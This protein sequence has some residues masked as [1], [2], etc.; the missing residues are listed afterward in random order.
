MHDHLIRGFADEMSKQA[1]L[2]KFLLGAGILGAGA[3]GA[4]AIGSLIKRPRGEGAQDTLRRAGRGASAGV[5]GG[6]KGLFSGAAGLGIGTMIGRAMGMPGQIPD[7]QAA[8]LL[9]T[10]AAIG[11]VSE[12]MQ[13]SAQ[14]AH[15]AASG[16]LAQGQDPN[17]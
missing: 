6:V 8:P 17:Q 3:A 15:R 13:S 4:G 12:G 7:T 2:G 9:A 11:A 5:R 10:A 1:N 16:E 14:D